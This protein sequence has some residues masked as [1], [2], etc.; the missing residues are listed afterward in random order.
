MCFPTLLGDRLV[1]A[2]RNR[3]TRQPVVAFGIKLLG[4]AL[5]FAFNLAVARQFGAAGTGS[6]G[7]AL[8]TATLAATISLIGLDYILLRTVAGDLKV[9]AKSEARGAIRTVVTAVGISAT[10]VAVITGTVAIPLMTWLLDDPR[11]DNAL[12]LAAFAIVPVALMR[13]ASVGLRSTGQILFA[14][15]LD[16]PL[17]MLITLTFFGLLLVAGPVMEVRFLFAGYTLATILVCLIAW[18]RNRAIVRDWPASAP[19]PLGPMLAQS[20]RVSLTV[21]SML[22]IEWLTMM[23]VGSRGDAAMVGQLRTAL[24]ITSLINLIVVTFDSVMGPRI[25]AAHRV[26]D[27]A[28][29][30]RIWRNS[31][32]LMGAISAPLLLLCLLL[33]EWLLG[34]FGP[35]FPAAAPALRILVIGQVIN[36]LT[37]PAGSTLVMTG[38]EVW[39]LRISVAALVLLAGLGLSLV[40]LYGLVG[41]AATVTCVVAFRN[42]AAAAVILRTLK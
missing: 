9:G 14:Q 12:T 34:L 31:I 36:V 15:W 33:P 21:L 20:W 28:A 25:A 29:I 13:T 16:G 2:A 19:V 22:A 10:I 6:F 4:A 39:S 42:L 8:T 24:Q 7:L 3:Q 1:R 26:G 17:S 18:M 27:T 5:S 30:K 37:G 23:I 32:V 11:I 35:E 41:A 38:R 40:P